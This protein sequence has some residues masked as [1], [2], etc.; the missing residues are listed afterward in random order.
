MDDHIDEIEQY[1]SALFV[2]CPAEDS[3]IMLFSK[4]FNLIGYGTGL[5]VTCAG[6]DEEVICCGAFAFKVEYNHIGAV[7]FEGDFS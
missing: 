1:P 5:A 3:K 2:A 7:S 4:V 6:S